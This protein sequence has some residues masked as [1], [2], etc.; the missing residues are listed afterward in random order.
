[1]TPPATAAPPQPAAPTDIAYPPTG[2]QQPQQ[3]LEV[4]PE[5]DEFNRQMEE[6]Q[7]EADWTRMTKR[8]TAV[9]KV[10]AEM[11]KARNAV[12]EAHQKATQSPSA[13]APS[14]PLNKVFNRYVKGKAP[15][16]TLEEY[17]ASVRAPSGAEALSWTEEAPELQDFYSAGGTPEELR[18][19]RKEEADRITLEKYAPQYAAPFQDLTF[20]QGRELVGRQREHREATMAPMRTRLSEISERRKKLRRE[21]KAPTAW[22]MMEHKEKVAR[23]KAGEPVPLKPEP[24]RYARGHQLGVIDNEILELEAEIAEHDKAK[25]YYCL[26]YT[27]PSPRDATLSRMPSSA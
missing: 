18:G 19:I 8:E 10:E 2:F 27:S 4:S 3:A 23:I 14:E 21:S 26:L 6:E 20:G 25:P 12:A 1:M 17:K 24:P 7:V 13:E 22:D 11:Q 5:D 15:M 9:L 16:P